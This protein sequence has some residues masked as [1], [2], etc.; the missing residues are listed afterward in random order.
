MPW[1]VGRQGVGCPTNADPVIL[2][3][4]GTKSG[5]RTACLAGN[6]SKVMPRFG[7]HQDWAASVSEE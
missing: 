4:L 3:C 5:L 7:A 2:M 6:S 1:L